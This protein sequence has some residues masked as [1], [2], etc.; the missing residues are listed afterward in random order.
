MKPNVFL[1]LSVSMFLFT[2][3]GFSQTKQLDI[4]GAIKIGNLSSD[5]ALNTEARTIRWNPDNKDFEG[6]DGFEWK[7]LTS[8]STQS[9]N[10]SWGNITENCELVDPDFESGDKFGESISVSGDV[11]VIGSWGHDGILFD[12]GTNHD[13]GKICIFEKS[14]D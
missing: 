13:K 3:S 7:S 2:L 14:G 12:G 6:W 1:T 5:P 11:A 9:G 4:E 10:S 8:G